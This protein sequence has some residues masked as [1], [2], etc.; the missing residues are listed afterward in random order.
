MVPAWSTGPEPASPAHPCYPIRYPG[1]PQKHLRP[2]IPSGSPA[3]IEGF[4][5]Q[6]EKRAVTSI[7]SQRLVPDPACLPNANAL[8]PKDPR[9]PLTAIHP[10][11]SVLPVRHLHRSAFASRTENATLG[12]PAWLWMKSWLEMNGWLPASQTPF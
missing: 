12:Y 5:S 8:L 3:A 9:W 6:A 4:Q 2:P 11:S 7:L 10:A 1:S